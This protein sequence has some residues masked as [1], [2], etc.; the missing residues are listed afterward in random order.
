MRPWLLWMLCMFELLKMVSVDDGG[1]WSVPFASWAF[2]NIKTLYHHGSKMFY[3]QL[4]CVRTTMI[5][6]GDITLAW[7]R[8]K[9]RTK[10]NFAV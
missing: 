8:E 6:L 4:F 2:C 9:E 7:D 1:C 3:M 5:A 10:N